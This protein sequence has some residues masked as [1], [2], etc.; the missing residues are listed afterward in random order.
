MNLS[1]CSKHLNGFASHCITVS[2]TKIGA[3]QPI[4]PAGVIAEV[5]TITTTKVIMAKKCKT[6]DGYV[7]YPLTGVEQTRA[8]V[9]LF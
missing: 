3:P 4:A 2:G 8:N 9:T 6:F 5:P 7:D 1:N